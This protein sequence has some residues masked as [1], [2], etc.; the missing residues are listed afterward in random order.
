MFRSGYDFLNVQYNFY[1]NLNFVQHTT[2]R[3]IY[4]RDNCLKR[5]ENKYY[6]E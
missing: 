4:Q 2:T 6:F 5:F 1:F 3:Y